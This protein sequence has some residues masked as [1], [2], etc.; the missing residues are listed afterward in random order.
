MVDVKFHQEQWKKVENEMYEM[1][2]SV[3]TGTFSYLERISTNLDQAK[4]KIA[5]YDSDGVVSLSYTDKRSD[6]LSLRR[7]YSVL[8]DYGYQVGGLIDDKIDHPFYVDM[9][10]FVTAMRDATITTYRTENRIGATDPRELKHEGGTYEYALPKEEAGINDLFQGDSYYSNK[11]LQEF[12]MWQENQGTDDIDYDAY[13]NGKMNSGAFQY[14]SI[15]DGQKSKE[16]WTG[17]GIGAVALFTGP[18][19]GGIIGG[20]MLLLEG[21]SAISGK[22]WLTGRELDDS[23]RAWRAIF[24]GGSALY[25]GVKSG[26]SAIRAFGSRNA[27]QSIQEIST[28]SKSSGK[29]FKEVVEE[30]RSNPKAMAGAEAGQLTNASKQADVGMDNSILIPYDV[31]L[32]KQINKQIQ[33]E[34]LNT[35]DQPLLA[36]GTDGL[37]LAMGKNGGSSN[38]V[39]YGSGR[40]SSISS[41]SRNTSV[42]NFDAK[43]A[44]NKQKGNFGEIVSSDNLLNNQSLKDAGYDLKPAGNKGAPS[45]LND[46]IVKGIDGLYENTN[47]NSNVKYVIDEAKFGSSRLGRTKDGK[48]MSDSWILGT[49][50]KRN[51]ILKA[52]NNDEFLADEITMALQNYEVEKVLS[53]V[54]SDGSITTFRLDMDGNIVGEWP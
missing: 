46:K 6:Y 11:M 54:N 51:R 38:S 39:V 50:T 26:G 2:Q 16:T 41:G 48:Q 1:S 24:A 8:Y 17:V 33:D 29:D 25:G 28:L 32:D 27:S 31:L 42:Y 9:D 43:T 18:A 20:G 37:P 35:I 4:E 15:E 36:T 21:S 10:K 5:K 44:T 13:K 3:Y 34:M 47:P 14:N 45:D 52:V 40:I 19:V 7:D 12:N 49:N 22:D 30:L 23:E 53:K